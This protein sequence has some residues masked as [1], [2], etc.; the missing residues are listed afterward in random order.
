M[1]RLQAF[2]T[3]VLRPAAAGEDKMFMRRHTFHIFRMP[4]LMSSN[5]MKL[6]REYISGTLA[7]VRKP[8]GSR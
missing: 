2:N 4:R 1:K 8:A 6:N 5:D 7:V 3:D